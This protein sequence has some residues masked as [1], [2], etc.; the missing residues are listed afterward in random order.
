MLGNK[1]HEQSSLLHSELPLYI[2]SKFNFLLYINFVLGGTYFTFPL[3]TI[4]LAALLKKM[5]YS[6]LLASLFPTGIYKKGKVQQV[7]T[8]Q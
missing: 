1:V 5:V 8:K 6:I 7:I 2:L 4:D 3:G